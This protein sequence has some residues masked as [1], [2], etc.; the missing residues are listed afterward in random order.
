M[1]ISARVF[2]G[3]RGSGRRIDERR[4]TLVS[5]QRFAITFGVTPDG[6]LGADDDWEEATDLLAGLYPTAMDV[7]QNLS[8]RC[9]SEA[10]SCGFR[11]STR[12]FVGTASSPCI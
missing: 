12:V 5:V 10:G 11:P 1:A 7:A 3:S 9:G 6:E 4:A 2:G 8:T